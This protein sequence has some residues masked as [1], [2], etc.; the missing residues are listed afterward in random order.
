MISVQQQLY[1]YSLEFSF[2]IV[3]IKVQSLKYFWHTEHSNLNIALVKVMQRDFNEPHMMQVPIT[4]NQ[5]N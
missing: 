4:E 5:H 3:Q 1:V 2:Y